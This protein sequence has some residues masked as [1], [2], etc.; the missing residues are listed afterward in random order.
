MTYEE[1]AEQLA[2]LTV[3][4]ESIRQYAIEVAHEIS[5][6]D[7]DEMLGLIQEE[8]PRYE[9]YEKQAAEYEQ[10]VE[11]LVSSL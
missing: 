7:R 10:Q 11:E 6:E 3:I 8:V 2:L 4:P 1:F 9:E 5:D